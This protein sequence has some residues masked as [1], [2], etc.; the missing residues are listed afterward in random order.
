MM[1]PQ[2]LTTDELLEMVQDLQGRMDSLEG[3]FNQYVPAPMKRL[4]I[5]L[6]ISYLIKK[7]WLALAAVAHAL[8]SRAITK[9][10]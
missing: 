6:G 1:T 7:P 10:E 8:L 4:I 2:E 3:T 9:T 5:L